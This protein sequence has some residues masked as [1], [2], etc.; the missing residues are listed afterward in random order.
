VGTPSGDELSALDVVVVT[1]AIGIGSLLQGAA[2]FG[3]NLLAVP[4]LV[5]V[6]P[7]LV[8]GPA[9]VSALVLNVFVAH[10][11][12]GVAHLGETVWAIA[13]RVVGTVVGVAVL[14]V[15]AGDDIGLMVGIVLLL[16]VVA[17]VSGWQLRPTRPVVIG[18]GVASGFMATTVAVGGPAIALVYQRSEGPV[19]RA[20]LARYFVVG[21]AI[22]L[23][24]LA[25]G[26]QFDERSLRL[27]LLLV[28][29]TVAGFAVSHR[30][31]AVLDRGWTRSVVLGLTVLS[32]IVVL[33]DWLLT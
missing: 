29:G 22:S 20:T 9:L 12:R 6:D 18:A 14:A 3:A 28:P 15:V 19:L 7:A 33:V 17:S 26:G 2:G 32:A 23:V 4:V 30:L 8:P 16:S 1:V 31:A 25:V 27:G 21:A 10:R 13:G 11:E 5:L 24:A